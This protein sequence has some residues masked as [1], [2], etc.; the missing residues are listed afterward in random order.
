MNLELIGSRIGYQGADRRLSSTALGARLSLVREGEVLDLLADGSYT[1][2]WYPS[3]TDAYSPTS[4]REALLQP[5]LSLHPSDLFGIHLAASV[6]YTTA[7]YVDSFYYYVDSLYFYSPTGTEYPGLSPYRFLVN[8]PGVT[9]TPGVEWYPRDNWQVSLECLVE[10]SRPPVKK[11]VAGIP[12]A[13]GIIYLDDS[14][15]AVGPALNTGYLGERVGAGLGGAFRYEN[16]SEKTTPGKIY[17]G[18]ASSGLVADTIPGQRYHF[19]D[20]SRSWSVDADLSWQATAW[21][22]IMASG[23]YEARYYAPFLAGGRVSHNY[24][25]SVAAEARF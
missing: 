21:L 4:E 11:N 18:D 20:D 24:M 3:N 13:D 1:L 14:Y 8:T 7:A 9:V 17:R 15:T 19:T 16:I 22:S 10:T 25:G 5:D 2:D 23:S 6:S 12:I